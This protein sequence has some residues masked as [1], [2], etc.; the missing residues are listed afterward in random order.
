VKRVSRPVR[1]LVRSQFLF[2]FL[3]ATVLALGIFVGN[4]L[5]HAGAATTT[6]WPQ[7]WRTWSYSREINSPAPNPTGL[8]A[9][10]IPEDVYAHSSN[11]L[12]DIR[13]V[14]DA[15]KEVPYVLRVPSGHP[16]TDRRPVRMQERSFAPGEFTQFV[17]DA[18]L[19][20]PFHN[21]IL[22]NTS[23][24]DFITWAEVA[25]S[26]DARQWRIVCDRAPLFRFNKQNLQGTQTL[27]YSETNARYVRLRILEGS[28]Q[29]P[30]TSVNVLYE[31][32]TPAESKPVSAQLHAVQATNPQEGLWR[33]DLAAEMPVNEVRFETDQPEFSRSVTIDSSEDGQEWSPVGSGEI[34][35][36]HHDDIL[37][38]WLQVSFAGGWSS[39]WRVHVKN[40][41][42]APLTA[43]QVSLYMTPRRIIFRANLVRRYLLLYGQSEAKPPL[44]DLERTIHVEDFDKLPQATLGAEQINSDYEDPRPWSERHPAVLW[45][46]VIIAAALLGA[47]ALRSLRTSP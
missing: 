37:R 7:A 13:I 16:H 10:V 21:S 46:A 38:E 39:H 33:A 36:F 1:S 25:V 26:D 47:A 31:V 14:N 34:Y 30:V 20:A 15:G 17:L 42:N 8:T 2:I 45:I 22:V 29:F 41:N 11:Q 35:R 40:G 6:A 24:T 4:T 27:H 43:A 23:E 18:G 28:H 44:Y 12:A 5:V 9:I 3:C 32:N 19:N